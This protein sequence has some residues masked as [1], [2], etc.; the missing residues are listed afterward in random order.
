MDIDGNLDF[1]NPDVLHDVQLL[2]SSQDSL[3][4]HNALLQNLFGFVD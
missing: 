3:G 2:T 4:N 1:S